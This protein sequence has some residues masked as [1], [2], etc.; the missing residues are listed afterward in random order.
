MVSYKFTKQRKKIYQLYASG[1]DFRDI[2]KEV[3]I[4]TTRVIQIVKRIEEKVSKDDLEMIKAKAARQ[5]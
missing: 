3:K 1:A 5:S 4:S 2:A